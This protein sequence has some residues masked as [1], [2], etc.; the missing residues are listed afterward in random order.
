M[1]SN[2]GAWLDGKGHKLRVAEADMPKAGPDHIVVRNHAVAV[3]PVDWK[4]QDSGYFVKTWPLILGVDVA[5]EVHEVGSNVTRFKK[6]DRV[7]GHT[8][9]LMTQT[10]QDGGF[11][12]YS[13]LVAG[14][15]AHLPQN[16]TF[17][18]GAVLP[19]ALDTAAVG[20]YSTGGAGL[21]LPFPSLTPK[22]S[23]KVIVVWGGSSSVG[24]LAIQLAV[25][26][27]AKVVTTS[28]SH[29]FDF[30]K[31]CGASE[32]V[33]YK[34]SSVVEDV[35]SA[36]EKLGGEFAGC[37]DAISLPDQS[38]KYTIPIIEKLGGG[39]L[40]VVLGPPENPPSSVK[41]ASVFGINEMTHKI[42]EEYVTPAL[43]QGKLK[44]LPE[45]L[46]V[47][48]GLESVQAGF[49]KNKAGVSARK[50]VIE[51]Q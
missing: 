50:V 34:S 31:S 41:A 36:V 21:G 20:L 13:R 37:Y 47:G 38:Y 23:N 17:T 25:A 49:D 39:V 40:A 7:A 15:A 44:C 28:S 24:A 12:L 27:G 19:L 18:S 9:S 26:S 6:G 33:D 48:K 8:I 32:T 16:I 10:P 14:K 43:E 29:N 22:P 1:A 2:Q 3:N 30:C 35:V 51:L 4:I 46:V 45:P 11:Q 42:W 5:G